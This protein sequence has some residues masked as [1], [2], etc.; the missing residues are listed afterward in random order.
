MIVRMVMTKSPATV[1]VHDSVGLALGRMMAQRIRRLP[2]VER[3]GKL[4]GI[5]STHDVMRALPAG[6]NPF[7][8]VVD[9]PELGDSVSTFMTDRLVTVTPDTPIEEAAR[10]MD[11]NKIGA[12]PVVHRGGLVG[13]IT[14]S[15]LG[16]VVSAVMACGPRDTRICFEIE[17]TDSAMRIVTEIAERTEVTLLGLMVVRSEPKPMGV[18]QLT[19]AG[20][21]DFVDGFWSAGCRVFSVLRAGAELLADDSAVPL[22][23]PSATD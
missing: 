5:L 18:V 23:T 4:V 2:V 6:T 7:A 1:D 16:R 15:D 12:L 9:C 11:A 13:I 14:T 8:A 3:R 21:D 10:L 20:A 19:G 17:E 22:Q